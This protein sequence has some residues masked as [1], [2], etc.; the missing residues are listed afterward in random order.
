MTN[1]DNVL[2]ITRCLLIIDG[3]THFIDIILW[4][5]VVLSHWSN[6]LQRSE[7]AFDNQ[8]TIKLLRRCPSNK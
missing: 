4:L 3:Q 1:R 6:D 7:I 2:I 5:S 8:Q